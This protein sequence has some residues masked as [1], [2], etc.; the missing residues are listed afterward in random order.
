MSG[1]R[2]KASSQLTDFATG[3]QVRQRHGNA[4]RDSPLQVSEALTTSQG[5]PVDHGDC[6][7]TIGERGPIPLQV[8]CVMVLYVF[9]YN[10]HLFW[11]VSCDLYVYIVCAR[12]RARD[13]IIDLRKCFCHLGRQ[14]RAMA[15]KCN[16]REIGH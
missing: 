15:D 16:E 6:T 8:I 7:M 9:E 14:T 1:K 12:G 5:C 3:K 10:E 2:S 11:R 4:S 13:V